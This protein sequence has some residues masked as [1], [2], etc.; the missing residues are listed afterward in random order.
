VPVPPVPSVRENVHEA[1][2]PQL[3]ATPV[4]GAA[5]YTKVNG[6][7][8]TTAPTNNTVASRSNIFAFIENF[9]SVN[10]RIKSLLKTL[11]H[12]FF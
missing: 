4:T 7:P 1:I 10:I 3:V 11:Q 8:S 2:P 6:V 9:A 12:Y 5:A